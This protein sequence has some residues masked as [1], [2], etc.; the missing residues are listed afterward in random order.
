MDVSSCDKLTHMAISFV[1]ALIFYRIFALLF[2]TLITGIEN[3]KAYEFLFRYRDG[4]LVPTTL[5]FVW[6]LRGI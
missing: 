2:L 6:W 3:N 4:F 5:A 1:L